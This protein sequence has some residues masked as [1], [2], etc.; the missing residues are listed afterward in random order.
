[1]TMF[2]SMLNRT[3]RVTRPALVDAGY[4]ASTQTLTLIADAV[5]CAIRPLKASERLSAQQMELPYD[6]VVFL[7]PGQDIRRGDRIEVT[8][9]DADL[10]RVVEVRNPGFRSHHLEVA[11]MGEVD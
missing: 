1:M 7:L 2:A 5:P 3:A 9:G 4:G 11:V 6:R 8:D 10:L